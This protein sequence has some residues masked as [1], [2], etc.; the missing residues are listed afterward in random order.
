M[1]LTQAYNSIISRNYAQ[2]LQHLYQW[3]GYSLINVHF[4]GQGGDHIVFGI[5]YGQSVADVL[6]LKAGFTT[7]EE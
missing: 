6:F 1:F 2:N 5:V 4:F 3:L 7:K